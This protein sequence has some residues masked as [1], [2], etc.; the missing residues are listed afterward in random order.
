MRVERKNGRFIVFV[1]SYNTYLSASHVE[2]NK[3]QN[4]SEDFTL[5]K[6]SKQ[7]TTAFE[8]VTAEQKLPVSYISAFKVLRNQQKLHEQ[9]QQT[10]KSKFAK[11]NLLKNAQSAYKENSVMFS[12]IKKPK[13]PLSGVHTKLPTNFSTTL[14][15]LNTYIENDNYYK[16][17]A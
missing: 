2:T 8:K 6:E 9:T 1:S 7:S 17:T 12:F 4:R 11:V 13:V 5:K 15:A 14:K 3:R 10:Q 16:V